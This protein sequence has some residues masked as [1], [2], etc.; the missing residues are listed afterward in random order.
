[1]YIFFYKPYYNPGLSRP[2][3]GSKARNCFIRGLS[4][5]L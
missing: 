5:K 4:L 1:M 2:L 3:D